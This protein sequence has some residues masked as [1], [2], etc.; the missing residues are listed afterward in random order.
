MPGQQIV[1]RLL[2]RR[3][4]EIQQVRNPPR[5]RDLL[6]APLARP[7]VKRPPLIDHIVHRPHSL[8][9]RGRRVRPVTVDH[10]HVLHVQPLQRGLGPLDDVLARQALV[11]GARP[12][13]EDLG[14]D[15]E[16][17]ALPAELADGLAHD[18]LG[19]A[20]GVDLGVVEEVDA[21]VAAALEKGLGFLDVQLVA[22]GH[23]RPVRQLG[24][25]QPRSPQ[26]LVLHLEF[27]S[28]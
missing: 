2:D 1:L 4:D 7:P 11:V 15:D 13:P 14:G 26:I 16:V 21:V 10:V 28:S 9:D 6:R 23:P 12:A 17:G 27:F 22:E 25:L 19:P 18:L 8:L 3:P 20:V 24:H 5:L